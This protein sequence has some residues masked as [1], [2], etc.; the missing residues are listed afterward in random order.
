MIWSF[1]FLLLLLITILAYL[2]LSTKDLISAALYLSAFSF[3]MCL[4]WAEMGAID[5]AFTEAAVGAGV[6]T[7]YLIATIIN[8]KRWSSD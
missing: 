7:V 8:T 6:S 3:S 2:A 1:N 5:V 4:I